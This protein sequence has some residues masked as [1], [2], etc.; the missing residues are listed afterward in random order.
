[1]E[2][3]SV[4]DRV[5]TGIAGLDAILMG[6]LLNGSTVIAQGP[7]G[8]GKTI[9]A[10][11]LAFHRASQGELVVYVTLVAESHTRLL[12]HLAHADLLRAVACRRS[13]PVSQR[14]PRTA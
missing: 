3:T 14:L 2:D 8:S 12:R 11:Q 4:T 1:M 9:L 10:N 13:N 6:G 7:P 5:T